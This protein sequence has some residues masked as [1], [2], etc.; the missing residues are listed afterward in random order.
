MAGATLVDTSVWADHVV[1]PVKELNALLEADDAVLTH[2]FIFGELYIGRFKGQNE[3]LA[4][5]ATLT[6]AVMADESEVLQLVGHYRL[7]G[8]GLSWIDCHLLA[9][10]KLSKANLLTHDLAMK[11]AWARMKPPR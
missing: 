9:S 2:P 11:Q 7:R 6:A 10:A 8:A 3:V 5:L 4:N 1:K